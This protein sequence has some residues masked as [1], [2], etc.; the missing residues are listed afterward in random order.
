[1]TACA[2]DRDVSLDHSVRL[3]DLDRIARGAPAEWFK[4]C[5]KNT[6]R[7]VASL[8]Q[9]AKYAGYA[10]ADDAVLLDQAITNLKTTGVIEYSGE[11][12]AELTTF[13]PFVFWLKTQ[14]LLDQRR[15]ITYPGMRPY[16][17]FL[18]D[19]EY[20]ERPGPRGVTHIKD[21]V[22][23]TNSTWHATRKTWHVMPDY[24][25]RYASQGLTFRRPVVFIQNKLTVEFSRGPINYIPISCL[26]R[27]LTLTAPNFDVVYSRPGAAPI[28]EGYTVDLN[29]FCDYPD[30]SAIRR[31]DHVLELEDY[32]AKTG[33]DY[34]LTKLEMMAKSRVFVAVQGGGTHLM[35]YFGNSLLLLLHYFGFEYPHAYAFGPYKFLAEPSPLLLLARRHKHFER[36]IELIGSIRPDGDELWVDR[37]ALRTVSQLRF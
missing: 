25:Q 10:S 32:C 36:A 35:A 13:L 6:F 34:N 31:F 17:Y 37:S 33:A 12:G 22:W 7:K 18:E 28:A 14:G 3:A 20:A 15:V 26:E 2:P 27:L 16:Y 8:R 11:Y 24:R 5:V 1:M 9:A 19:G 23:P 29:E 21:R 4:H 30:L